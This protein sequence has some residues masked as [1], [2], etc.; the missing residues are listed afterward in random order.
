MLLL[1]DKII[2]IV[3]KSNYFFLKVLQVKIKS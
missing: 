3:R 1:I 2:Q